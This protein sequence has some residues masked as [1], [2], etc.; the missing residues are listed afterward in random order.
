MSA[1][2]AICDLDRRRDVFVLHWHDGENRYN[3]GSVEALGAALDEV[4]AADGPKALVVVGEGK[5]WSNGLDLDWMGAQDRDVVGAFLDDVHRLLVRVLTF[6]CATVAALNGHSFAGGA[7][8]AMAC[9]FRVMRDDRGYWCLPEADLG[10][11]LTPV[12]HGVVA[13]KLPR[14]TAHEA[15]LTGRRYTAA[16]ALEAQI[17]H[18]VAAEADVLERAVARAEGLVA[19]GVMREHKQLMYGEVAALLP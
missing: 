4:D 7:M 12:M 9:A 11:P 19:K 1:M 15:I 8:L 18:E 5:Y 16:E 14:V 2:S 6:P 3:R 13:A 17:I 10:L